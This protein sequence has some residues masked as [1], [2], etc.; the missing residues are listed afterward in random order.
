MSEMI[1]VIFYI[2]LLD[3]VMWGVFSVV[4]VLRFIVLEKKRDIDLFSFCIERTHIG[5]F[6]TAMFYFGKNGF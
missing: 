3:T 2:L 1:N 5:L 4:F 6:L